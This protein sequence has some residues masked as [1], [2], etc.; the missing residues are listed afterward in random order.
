MSDY[1]LKMCPLCCDPTRTN[2]EV[3]LEESSDAIDRYKA[4]CG[5]CGCS[6]PAFLTKIEAANFWN[7]RVEKSLNENCPMC[8]DVH[9]FLEY[10]V[11]PEQIEP[12]YRY[13]CKCGFAG[14]V[15]K[16]KGQIILSW[17]RR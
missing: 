10:K 12:F 4:G 3:Y 8:N 5:S 11:R 9:D 2:M 1:K 13:V 7:N 16:N 17:T 14:G 15:S 6:T